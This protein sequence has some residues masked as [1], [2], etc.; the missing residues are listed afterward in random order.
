[1]KD[2]LLRFARMFAIVLA[3]LLPVELFKGATLA[4]ALRY[5]LFWAG[6]SSLVYCLVLAYRLRRERAYVEE[7]TRAA[8]QERQD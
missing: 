8:S 5:G 3:V 4:G 7:V 1:M 6:A 2:W